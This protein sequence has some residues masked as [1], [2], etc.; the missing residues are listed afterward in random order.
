MIEPIIQ[1]ISLC[2]H[3]FTNTLLML[4]MWL[5]K[6]KQPWRCTILLLSTT[7]EASSYCIVGWLLKDCCC[8]RVIN[9]SNQCQNLMRPLS[10]KKEAKHSLW[11]RLL[12]FGNIKLRMN[13]R[14]RLLEWLSNIWSGLHSVRAKIT[15][16]CF[17]IRCFCYS[18]TGL[19]WRW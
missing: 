2:S 18:W 15:S 19:A 5:I 8:R 9:L 6:Q 11:L 3:T 17:I 1:N 10:F 4:F 13:K 16:F 12:W 7:L 14:K